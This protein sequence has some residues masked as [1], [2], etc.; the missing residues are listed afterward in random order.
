MRP[1]SDAISARLA[2]SSTGAG[3]EER[4]I[5]DFCPTATLAAPVAPN[6]TTLAIAGGIDID[7]VRVGSYAMLGA[8]I[9]RVDAVTPSVVRVGRGCLDTVPVEHAKGARLFFADDALESD[10][11]E[12]AQGENVRVKLMPTTSL[13]K[14]AIGDAPE[15]IATMAQRQARPYPP[16]RFRING[17]EYPT[18]MR[19]DQ[20]MT[21]S[22]AHRDRLQQTAT[23]VDTEAASIGPEAG[24]SYTLELY[25]AAGSLISSA[26]EIAG[27]AHT[28]ALADIGQNFGE[29]RI[30]LWAVREGLASHS[31]HEHSL[32]RSG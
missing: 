30:K 17:Q 25:S 5:V 16:G 32:V 23:I 1:S 22:W 12:Y 3:Y 10:G 24:T 19:G 14:L 7:T 8:E 29:M 26:S 6:V 2:I 31:A 11:V 20:D 21:V 9:V 18:T 27:N 15:Q 28:F 4:G 13:G